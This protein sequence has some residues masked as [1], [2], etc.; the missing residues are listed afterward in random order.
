VSRAQNIDGW[1]TTLDTLASQNYSYKIEFA[2]TKDFGVPGAVIV[3]NDH[4][5]EFLLVSFSLTLPDNTEVHY[6]T[7]SW[8]YNTSNT[9]PRI[10]FQ[11][12]VRS[13]N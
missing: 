9:D 6:M 5:N 10:F 1:V 11:N 3:R 13:E 4:P 12:K 2:V 7:N 8:V